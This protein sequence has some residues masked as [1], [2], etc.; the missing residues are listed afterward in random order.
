MG[1]SND[2]KYLDDADE[3]LEKCILDIVDNGEQLSEVASEEAESS[4]T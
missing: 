2:F 3:E 1:L 4:A